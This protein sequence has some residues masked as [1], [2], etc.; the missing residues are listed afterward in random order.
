MDTYHC[1][2]TN[3]EIIATFK[4]IIN[5]NSVCTLQKIPDG[6]WQAKYQQQYQGYYTGG[7]LQQTSTAYEK[8]D[9]C[10]VIAR[11]FEQYK[12][13]YESQKRTNTDKLYTL[14]SNH[15]LDSADRIDLLLKQK[16]KQ[17]LNKITSLYNNNIE[18]IQK[19]YLTFTPTIKQ[20][21]K[22]NES[23]ITELM[24]IPKGIGLLICFLVIL[25]SMPV[26]LPILHFMENKQRKEENE[27]F[28]NLIAVDVNTV[29]TD[30]T[31]GVME[32]ESAGHSN[33]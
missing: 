1:F 20:Q 32:I 15:K 18:S 3:Q 2:S 29:N 13:W 16:D 28:L 12:Y 5:N 22:I 11:A 33:S 23:I 19:Q 30:N 27:A 14:I 4:P 21:D 6:E 31:S 17:I 7:R 26:S 24:A 8:M 25:V 9:N 10:F